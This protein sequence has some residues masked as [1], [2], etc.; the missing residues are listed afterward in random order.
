LA[1][2]EPQES[3]LIAAGL[4][5]VGD[6]DDG[7]RGARAE[8]CRGQSCR[9]AAP[10]RKPLQRVANRAAIDHARAN[11]A[12]GGAEVE[13]RKRVGD[14]IDDPGDRDQGAADADHDPR[15]VFVDEIALDRYQPGL[16]EDEDRE[17]D[18]DGRA[19][20]MVFLIDRIDEQRPSVL[21]VGNH[22]HADDAEN[23]LPPTSRF[24][25]ARRC[26]WACCRSHR[27]LLGVSRVLG[28]F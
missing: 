28:R 14:R 3:G 22:H 6:R 16:G 24:R 11:P 18:L 27:L 4:D 9:E 13:Q 25:C 7:E 2:T 23:Q 10:V 21:Q 26:G 15:A 1:Q 20:P 5:H 19:S 8:S 17:G 12:D